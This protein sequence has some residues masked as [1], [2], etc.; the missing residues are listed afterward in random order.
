[1]GPDGSDPQELHAAFHYWAIYQSAVAA[2]TE[3]TKEEANV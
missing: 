2:M 1:V 3:R